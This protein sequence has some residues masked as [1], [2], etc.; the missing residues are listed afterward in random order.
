MKSDLHREYCRANKTSQCSQIELS[1]RYRVNVWF[2]YYSSEYTRSSLLRRT[3]K[4]IL[5]KNM[6][7]KTWCGKWF[8]NQSLEVFPDMQNDRLH[9]FPREKLPSKSKSKTYKITFW[10]LKWLPL[11]VSCRCKPLTRS[12]MIFYFQVSEFQLG[13]KIDSQG[14]TV[15]EYW[16]RTTKM[17]FQVIGSCFKA[18]TILWHHQ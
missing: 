16:F 1:A 9:G 15:Q 12:W 3:E 2:F 11:V 7:F 4:S 8:W 18:I 6:T 5:N 10:Q 17:L 13:K 14:S